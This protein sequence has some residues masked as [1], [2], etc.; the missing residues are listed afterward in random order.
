MFPL[1]SNAHCVTEQCYCRGKVNFAYSFRAVTTNV[2]LRFGLWNS[3][4]QSSTVGFEPTTSGLEVRRAIH[5]ATRTTR[6]TS[7]HRV[8]FERFRWLPYGVI[9]SYILW[10]ADVKLKAIL[11]ENRSSHVMMHDH[12]S[13]G[14]KRKLKV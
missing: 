1:N 2:D 9:I 4:K 12:E 14:S 6:I 3:Q 11:K 10:L 7:D 8:E 5:C 13:T